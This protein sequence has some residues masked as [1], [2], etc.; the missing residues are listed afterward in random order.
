MKNAQNS[1]EFFE[2]L[3]K[4]AHWYG[5]MTITKTQFERIAE[6]LETTSFPYYYT[7]NHIISLVKDALLQH[8]AYNRPVG[9]YT[10]IVTRLSDTVGYKYRL[11][12]TKPLHSYKV[13]YRVIAASWGWDIKVI[14][15][16]PTTP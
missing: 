9:K 16:Y 4:R 7:A 6:N 2:H 3:E 13:V 12:E 11:Y 14:T 5:T 8:N 1:K 15:A 10:H